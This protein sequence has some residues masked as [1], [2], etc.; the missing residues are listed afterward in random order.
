[1]FCHEIVKRVLK[2]SFLASTHPI[3]Q[4]SGIFWLKGPLKSHMSKCISLKAIQYFSA[5]VHVILLA[6]IHVLYNV[7][8]HDS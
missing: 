3:K 5:T 7:I 2:M 4:G 8:Q 1:M 6:A